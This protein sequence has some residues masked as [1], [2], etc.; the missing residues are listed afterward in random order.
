[1]PQNARTP[2][3]DVV[4]FRAAELLLDVR[5]PQGA[6]KLLDPIIEN[7]PEQLSVRLLRGR[8]YFLSAQLRR[9]EADFR[10][11]VER[12]PDNAYAHYVLGRTLE[13]GGRDD[14]ARPHFRLAAALDPRPDFWEAAGFGD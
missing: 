7:H 1:M 11:I 2:E 5:D 14:E 13:R 12:E 8:A 3:T 4:D 6:V 9:A 10:V